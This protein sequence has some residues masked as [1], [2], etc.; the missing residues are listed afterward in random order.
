MEPPFSLAASSP[1][2]KSTGSK[3]LP[4]SS[5]KKKRGTIIG[6]SGTSVQRAVG[7]NDSYPNSQ[8]VKTTI[9][10]HYVGVPRAGG[11]PTET[12]IINQGTSNLGLTQKG[13]M[14]NKTTT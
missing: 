7:T 10:P 1:I 9:N 4:K 5:H 2:P 14:Q 8:S 11:P 12:C 13:I 3:V 6:A